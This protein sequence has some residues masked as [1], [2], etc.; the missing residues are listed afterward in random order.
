VAEQWQEP[1]PP[2]PL[3][4]ISVIVPVR[5]ESAF[6][7][8]TLNQLLAQKYD[9]DRYEILVADGGSTDGTP[10]IVRDLASRHENLH[11]LT[12][13]KKWSS[14]GRNVAIERARGDILVIVD[15]HCEIN[16]RNYLQELAS[17]FARSGAEC[18]GRPQPLK[19]QGATTLQKAIATARSSPL[20]HHPQSYIYSAVERYVEPQ[21]V[22][23]AYRRE[24]FEKI[25]LFDE[26]FDACED[27]ELNHRI[28]RAG[29]RCFFTPSVAVRYHPRS[30]LKGLFLQMARYGRGRV[31]L[32]RKHP[33]TF[34]LTG[35]VPAVF[36]LGL[37]AGPLLAA[38]SAAW[39]ALYAAAVLVY[40]LIIGAESGRLALRERS[41][42]LWPW[43]AVTFV[44]IHTGAGCG[45][46][47]ELV[48][49]RDERQ[50]WQ[51]EELWPHKDGKRREEALV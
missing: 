16:N 50:K 11:L 21:S 48:R 28:A 42:A 33:E 3:P 7:R 51:G 26:S 39:G 12:N 35:F 10:G 34:T 49:R 44:A 18:V 43:I 36:V 29:M 22:A 4:F 25:G 31:R 2:A 9:R 5:N 19:V 13:R 14:A 15:G 23:V 47:Q 20:G 30:T 41:F 40:L 17:A 45:I 46:I 32:L 6:I 38:L 24:V 27:V 1:A 37:G 8:N